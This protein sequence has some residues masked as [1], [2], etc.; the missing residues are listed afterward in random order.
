MRII[1]AEDDNLIQTKIIP[2]KKSKCHR[3]FD[4][5]KNISV[6][7]YDSKLYH[8]GNGSHSSVFG[9]LVTI[10]LGIVLL[11]YALYSITICFMR[12]NYI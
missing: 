12:V 4:C 7:Q 5:L 6:G 10:F 11:S 2:S 8:D 1:D 9:G 3:C